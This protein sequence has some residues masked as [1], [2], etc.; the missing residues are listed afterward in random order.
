VLVLLSVLVLLWDWLSLWE[1]GGAALGSG[2]GAAAV[3]AGVVPVFG[4]PV[5]GVTS[6]WSVPVVGV[7]AVRA[8]GFAGVVSVPV[9]G[10]VAGPVRF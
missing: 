9:P 6:F 2:A 5:D 7:G 10:I 4:D 3:G 8:G 1:L